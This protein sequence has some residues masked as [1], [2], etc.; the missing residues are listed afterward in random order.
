MFTISLTL[1]VPARGE[2]GYNA[3]LIERDVLGVGSGVV[4]TLH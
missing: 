2:E 4:P 1:M 3:L